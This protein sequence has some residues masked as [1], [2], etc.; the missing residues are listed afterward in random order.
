MFFEK[1]HARARAE[2]PDKLVH[3]K[4]DKKKH[5]YAPHGMHGNPSDKFHRA[6]RLN[7]LDGL[8][9]RDNAVYELKPLLVYY[10]SYCLGIPRL[11]PLFYFV[12][13]FYRL[14]IIA[15]IEP[16]KETVVS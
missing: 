5:E 8:A 10:E 11:R 7:L 6:A 1:S 12:Y 4:Q 9:I 16:L 3:E 13:L 2:N 14:R 15:F